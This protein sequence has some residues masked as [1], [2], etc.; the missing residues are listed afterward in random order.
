MTLADAHTTTTVA[1]DSQGHLDADEIQLDGTIL[2][3][4]SSAR[5]VQ[6]LDRIRNLVEVPWRA[7]VMSTNNFPIAAGIA[8]SAS[9]FAALTVA[10]C[11]ALDA[12][13]DP[14]QIAILARKGSGSAIRS[15]YAGFVLWDRG[16]GDSTSIAHQICP[17]EYW[18]LYDL[19]AVVSTATKHVSS[20]GGHKLAATSPLNDGRVRSA[21][22]SLSHVHE[23]VLRARPGPPRPP[24]RA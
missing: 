22:D 16:T 3:R 18:N 13:L 17:P 24:D 9:G 1:W 11:R 23:A 5:I 2:D 8:S 20:A 14:V 10:A 19:V 12:D 21:E 15:L 6:H 4:A 7:R